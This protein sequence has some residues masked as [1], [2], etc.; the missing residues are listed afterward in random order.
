M[1][2][3]DNMIKMVLKKILKKVNNNFDM[4]ELMNKYKADGRTMSVVVTDLGEGTGF[5]IS[6]GIL[7]DGSIEN[8]TCTV[9]VTRE[10][11]A[12]IITNKITQQ[13]AFLMGG[14]LIKSNERLRDSIILNR[15]F[16]EMK[17]IIVKR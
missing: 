13:Q 16:D 4:T 15:I 11:L 8:P 9:H 14:V 1:S 12:A 6:D 17:D 10:I 7:I 2:I 5:S 3:K